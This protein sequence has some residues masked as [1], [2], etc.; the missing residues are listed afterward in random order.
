MIYLNGIQKSVLLLFCIDT[1][2]IIHVLKN[3]K[4]SEISIL[5]NA[6]ISF[7]IQLIR[8]SNNIIYEYYNILKKNRMY[9][10][11]F[12]KYIISILENVKNL[13][14]SK[15]LL[16]NFSIKNIFL[17]NIS[18]LE[19]LG[20]KNIFFLIK[21]ENFSIISSLLLYMNNKIFLSILLFFNTHDR[22]KILTRM[23]NFT[24]LNYFGFTELN[25]I[26]IFFL[27][28]CNCSFLEKNRIDKIIN[29]LYFFKKKNIIKYIK[30]INTL[31]PKY[32]YLT[33]SKYFK[34]E[35][36]LN[37]SNKN[38][39]FIIKNNNIKNLCI[40]LNISN[41]FIKKKF[42]SNMSSIEYNYFKKYIQKNNCISFEKMYFKKN[43]L[44]ENIKRYIRN[45]KI[46]II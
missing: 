31:Y 10:F 42:I 43:L 3:F 19:L 9:T 23:I 38:I 21:K 20:S 16:K 26:V 35:N 5:I 4:K 44:L 15:K 34:F 17:N 40:I 32:L 45:G 29:I 46:L 6:I 12:K 37:F 22:L 27:Y 25:K 39:K 41:N 24:G 2:E 36:I 14:I 28:K 13:D 7:D 1:K 18:L 11:N 8:Y 33:I 30:N